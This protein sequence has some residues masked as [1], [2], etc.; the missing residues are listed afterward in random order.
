MVYNPDEIEKDYEEYNGGCWNCGSHINLKN[1]ETTCG[2]CD[3]EI[4]FPC[5]NCHKTFFVKDKKTEKQRKMCRV[6]GYFICPFCNVCKFDCQKFT[7]KTEIFKILKKT[8]PIGQFSTL[9]KSVDEIVE[10]IEGIKIS[11]DKKSC[12]RGVPISY[13]KG[14]IKKLLKRIKGFQTKNENDKLKFNERLTEATNKEIGNVLTVTKIRENGSYGQEFRDALN[15]LVCMGKYKI[16][17]VKN[18]DKEYSL[19]E[20]GAFS[21]CQYFDPDKVFRKQC[22][23]C[24]TK[25]SNDV[26]NCINKCV[27]KKGKNIGERA[28]LKRCVTNCDVCQKYRMQF[29]KI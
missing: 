26:D 12:H 7:W 21:K 23:K 24:K 13:G 25:Y 20:R 11:I 19:F 3:A 10:Y 16:T 6:C 22:T 17:N 14:K 28:E 9:S 18:E 27:W 2:Y 8:I 29:E 5:N 15:L 1:G 4:A